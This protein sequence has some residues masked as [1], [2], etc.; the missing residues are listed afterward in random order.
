MTL[1]RCRRFTIPVDFCPF[2]Q[3]SKISRSAAATLT[4]RKQP[5]LANIP[6]DIQLD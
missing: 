2:E 3:V 5:L 1:E 6:G 4:A